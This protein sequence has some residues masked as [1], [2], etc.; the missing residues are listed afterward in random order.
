MKE[1]AINA[2]GIKFNKVQPSTFLG[3]LNKVDKKFIDMGKVL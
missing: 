3:Q 1:I 2:D